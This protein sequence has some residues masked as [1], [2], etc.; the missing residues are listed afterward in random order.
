MLK[1]VFLLVLVTGSFA[2]PTVYFKE[3]FTDG[4]KCVV[5]ILSFKMYNL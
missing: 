2:E 5:K 3:G 1:L 4:S